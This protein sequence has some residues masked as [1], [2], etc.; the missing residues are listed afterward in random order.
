MAGGRSTGHIFGDKKMKHEHKIMQTSLLVLLLF[1][2]STATT[3]AQ[4]QYPEL[5]APGSSVTIDLCSGFELS[6]N[7]SLP[8]KLLFQFYNPETG[9]PTFGNLTREERDTNEKPIPGRVDQ[10]VTL[11]SGKIY[12]SN[13]VV[14]LDFHKQPLLWEKKSAQ[15]LFDL[16]TKE[17][18]FI[19]PKADGKILMDLKVDITWPEGDHPDSGIYQTELLIDHIECNDQVAMLEIMNQFPERFTRA[20]AMGIQG[21]QSS[22]VRYTDATNGKSVNTSSNTRR[23][24]QTRGNLSREDRIRQAKS[25]LKRTTR[26]GNRYPR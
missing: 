4:E 16:F 11:Y 3:E 14:Y 1:I 15:W 23:S 8:I 9:Q 21:Q 10:L 18:N 12:D 19:C 7:P 6:V 24:V 5:I 20:V 17:L 26:S 25:R 13:E 2:S 22:F